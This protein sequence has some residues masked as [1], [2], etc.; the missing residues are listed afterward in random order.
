MDRRQFLA[1]SV[2][3]V[4]VGISA[5]FIALPSSVTPSSAGKLVTNAVATSDQVLPYLDRWCLDA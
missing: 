5:F 3:L 1:I 4:V 2:L